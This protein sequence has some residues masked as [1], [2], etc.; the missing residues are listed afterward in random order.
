MLRGG[1]RPFEIVALESSPLGRLA[2]Q[3]DPPLPLENASLGKSLLYKVQPL[4]GL[5]FRRLALW[6]VNALQGSIPWKAI[7]LENVLFGKSLL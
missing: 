3:N 6:K 4:E 2:L 1:V 7:A 5:C